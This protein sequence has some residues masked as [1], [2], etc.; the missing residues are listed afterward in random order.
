MATTHKQTLKNHTITKSR[1]SCQDKV[2]KLLTIPCIFG[3][4]GGM[5][6]L[7]S[8]LFLTLCSVSNLASNQ[9][10]AGVFNIP[11]FVEYKSWALGME[12]EVTLST[13]GNTNNSGIADTFKFT[14][15][16]SPLSNLQVGMG[17]GSGSKGFRTGATYTFDFI[18]DLEGQ[19]GA[20]LALQAYYYKL[21]GSYGQTE[22][23]IYPYLH[24]MIKNGAAK[25]SDAAYDPFI[26]L[27]FGEAFYNSTY[28]S[29]WQLVVGASLKSSEHFAITGEIGIS[30]KD[31]DS[32]IS[33]GITYRD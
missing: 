18:P 24:K 33:G 15:G 20:G 28:R 3:L 7:I 8:F 13:Y 11:E 16:I 14:Y 25:E 10:V 21:K 26:A 22:A 9:A 12:P 19:L 4:L 32:Y 23:T 17:E 30:L 31:T 1:L 6:T 5:K 27:P 2:S 29:I